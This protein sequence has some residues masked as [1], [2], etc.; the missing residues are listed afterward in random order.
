[1]RNL[2]TQT[3]GVAVGSSLGFIDLLQIVFIVLK[4]CGV[5]DWHWALVLLPITIEVGLAVLVPPVLILV[6]WLVSRFG[7]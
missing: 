3:N 4:L 5:I 2:N 7:E 6:C 1:M